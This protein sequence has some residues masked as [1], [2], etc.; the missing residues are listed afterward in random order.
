M[1]VVLWLMTLIPDPHGQAALMLCEALALALV[2]SGLLPRSKVVEAIDGVIEVKHEIAGV[3][4]SVV[5]SA[6]SISLLQAISR[7][8]DTAR[9]SA[10]VV[11]C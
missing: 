11:I 6:V 8:I 2:E 10:P 9:V 4:E 7:S 1:T 5:V 3:S